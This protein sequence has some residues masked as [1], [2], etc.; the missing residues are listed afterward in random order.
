MSSLVDHRLS[1]G[2]LEKYRCVV[3]STL[4]LTSPGFQYDAVMAHRMAQAAAKRNR[5]KVKKYSA[6]FDISLI[7]QYFFDLEDEGSYKKKIE[8]LICLLKA[9]LGWRADDI[10]G[11]MRVHSLRKVAGGYSI[12]F[13]N[14]KVNKNSW[15]DYSFIPRLVDDYAN[16]DLC[17]LIDDV[18]QQSAK[19]DIDEIQVHNDE[20]GGN[21]QR[22]VDKPLLTSV[23]AKKGDRKV[24]PLKTTTVRAKANDACLNNINRRAPN[25][26]EFKVGQHAFRHA[27]ASALSDMKVP[28]GTAA[29]HMQT[30]EASMSK[31]YVVKVH[32]DFE[33]P[34]DCI[35]AVD[36]LALKLLI[37]FVH[38]HSSQDGNSCK[39]KQLWKR[40]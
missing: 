3:A 40:G 25:R 1:Q 12:R 27:V 16:L 29:E 38:W 2:T 34:Q 23:P 24:K 8:R 37:P 32:R 11:L 15:S 6:A 9:Q 33:L 22:A 5:P 30:S 21:Q 18:I 35:N 19:F 17:R 14:G 28:P 13:W 36:P 31:T 7:F 20:G 39:C 10:N 26:E 4:A